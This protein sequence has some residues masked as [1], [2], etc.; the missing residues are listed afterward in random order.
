M[1]DLRLRLDIAYD[2]T[3]FSGWAVQPGRRTVAG[4]L[5]EALRTVTRG[6]VPMV[7]A[8]RTDAG[9]H[10]TGQVAHIDVPTAVLPALVPRDRRSAD[11]AGAADGDARGAA[12][13]VEGAVIGL[14]RRLAGILPPDVRVWAVSVAPAGFDARFSALRRHYRYRILCSEWGLPPLHRAV[15]RHLPQQP[16]LRSHQSCIRALTNRSP[17]RASANPPRVS[18]S[19]T[20]ALTTCRRTAHLI[21]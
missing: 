5:G 12:W 18:G 7:V 17:T 4:V 14:R 16:T 3:A 13:I 6:P 8:G 2:G 10:A 20:S 19:C 21:R 15:A 11:G 9:V 1:P